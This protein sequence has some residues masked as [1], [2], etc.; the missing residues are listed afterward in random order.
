MN[1]VHGVIVAVLLLG[2]S[3]SAQQA[4]V[5]IFGKVADA[6]AGGAALDSV[7]VRLAK[8]PAIADTTDKNGAFSLTGR[9]SAAI[10]GTVSGA[11]PFAQCAGADVYFAVDRPTRVAVEAFTAAGR[12]LATP[13]DEIVSPGAYRLPVAAAAAQI[14]YVRVAC[15]GDV[16]VF[17]MQT[18]MPRKTSGGAP[19][20]MAAGLA[21]RRPLLSKTAGAAIDTLVFSRIGFAAQRLAIT[22]YTPGNS[23]DVS[24]RSDTGQTATMKAK[25]V[26]AAN[27]IMLA[28]Q[29][30]RNKNFK[31]TVSVSVFSHSQYAGVVGGGIDTFPQA[32]KDLYNRVLRLEGLLRP[33]Q[34]YFAS[35]E[36]LISGQT[37]GFYVPGTDSLYVILA[38]TATGLTLQDSMTIFHELVHALQDQYFGLAS[39]VDSAASSD[40]YYA[41]HYPVEGEAQ[42][43]MEYYGFKLATGAYPASATPVVNRLAE[44][45]TAVDVYL[46]SLHRAGEPLLSSM[47]FFWEYY[48][49]GPKFI[50]AIAGMNW[51]TIDTKIFRQLPL[52]TFEVLHPQQY[53]AGNEYVLNV[54]GLEM[55]LADSYE[56]VDEDELGELLSDVLFRE[57][58]FPSYRDIPN[59][60]TADNVIVYRSPQSDSLR[61]I[62]NT[63]W[64]DSSAAAGFF[65]GYAG[66]VGKKRNIQLPPPVRSG[67]YSYV[68]D[69]LR[70][71]YIEQS[72]SSVFTLENYQKSTLSACVTQCRAIK[73]QSA[74]LAKAA[75]GPSSKQP[76]VSKR[77]LPGGGLHPIRGA[78]H[79]TRRR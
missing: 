69:T 38:D 23:I 40:Q 25:V 59:G 54:R 77:R 18:M 56:L 72:K 11:M 22:S 16:R 60:M 6:D 7:T 55:S 51:S 1:K 57:W 4:Q 46:D 14:V 3:A 30:F 76:R 31:R 63:Y 37:A 79:G 27:S 21:S 26:A 28:V 17:R 44:E 41:A 43:L 49:C 62:W 32:Q 35:Y 19:A 36:S 24:M 9:I 61:M 47:P 65:A 73:P 67:K 12:R 45:Q 10:A 13:L 15:G 75:S 78:A 5:R 2:A 42:L 8:H 70:N 20:L 29:S 33:D 39:I 50:N 71:I 48:S 64:R 66:L 53:A 74:G 52:R 34:D 58:N 68:N